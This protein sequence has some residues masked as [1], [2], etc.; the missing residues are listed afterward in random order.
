MSTFFSRVDAAQFQEAL[1]NVLRSA[2]KRSRTIPVLEEALVEFAD[3]H[4][5]LTC[6]DLNQWCRATIPA[7]GGEFSF[8]F[9]RSKSVLA[10]CQYFSGDLDITY[11]TIPTERQ[12]DPEGEIC[13][14][15]GKHGLRRLTYRASDFPELPEISMEWHYPIN[16]EKLLER[17]KRIKYAVSQNDTRP[18]LCCIEFLDSRILALDGYRLALSRDPELTVEK[19]FFIP[20]EVMASLQMFKGKDCT[21]SVGKEWAAI[22]NETLR[23]YTH[24]P[25]KDGFDVDAAIPTKFEQEYPVPVDALWEEVKYLSGFLVSKERKPLRFDGRTLALTTSEGCYT[26]KIG[27][28]SIS[29]RGF[30]AK[31]LLEGLGQFKAKKVAAVTMKV[32]HPHA[33]IILTDG[34]ADLAMVLPVRLKESA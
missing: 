34:E 23:V 12:S 24:I 19:P 27:L 15:D 3:D 28:P 20:P 2:T 31:Y 4:C 17:F 13:I 11:T 22:G 30:D 26:S 8:V 5:T 18:T 21:I 6:T 1:S 16:A 29:A 25:I 32:G 7:N 9:T 10:A 14:C 33:P